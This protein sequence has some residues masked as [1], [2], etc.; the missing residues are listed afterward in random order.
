MS[1]SNH[2]DKIRARLLMGASLLLAGCGRPP[3]DSQLLENLLGFAV[4]DS[5]SVVKISGEGGMSEFRFDE[6]YSFEIS[7]TPECL[8]GITEASKRAFD[9]EEYPDQLACEDT[10]GNIIIFDFDHGKI[11]LTYST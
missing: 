11:D 8:S 10:R 4:C 3:T 5:A 1:T 6:V 9:C 2:L 7:G